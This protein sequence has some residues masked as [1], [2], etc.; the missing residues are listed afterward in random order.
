MRDTKNGCDAHQGRHR[1]RTIR[2]TT[3]F[4]RHNAGPLIPDGLYTP[5]RVHAL[6]PC[7]RLIGCPGNG[8]L[9]ERTT[10]LSYLAFHPSARE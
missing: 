2:G 3:L 6:L 1:S 9:P 8:E 5:R 10:L 4:G 7:H